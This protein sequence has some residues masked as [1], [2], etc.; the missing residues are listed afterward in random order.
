MLL[1]LSGA[2]SQSILWGVM[3]LGVFITYKMLDIADLSLIH[4]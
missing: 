4:I 1:A 3:V 2:I